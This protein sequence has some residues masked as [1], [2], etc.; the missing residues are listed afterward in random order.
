MLN[1]LRDHQMNMTKIQSLPVIETPWKYAFF[2]EATFRQYNDYAQALQL[3]E[4]MTEDLKV[5]GEYR[6]MVN[7]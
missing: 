5:L 2:I 6:L 3:L 4:V 1:V 7:S